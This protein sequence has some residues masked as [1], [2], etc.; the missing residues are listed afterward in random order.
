MNDFEQYIQYRALAYKYDTLKGANLSRSI[1]HLIDKLPEQG[2]EAEG[3]NFPPVKNVCAKVSVELSERLDDTVS[4]LGMSKRQFI[5][6]ALIQALDFADHMLE[7]V[8]VD[9]A[10]EE[11][12]EAWGKK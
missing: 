6:M 8:G 11:A 5:E 4:T 10:L 9:Q 7:C 2:F 12:G 1:D 3:V